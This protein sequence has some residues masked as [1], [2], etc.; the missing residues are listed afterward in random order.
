MEEEFKEEEVDGNA[1]GDD[2][3]SDFVLDEDNISI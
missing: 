1:G 2:D 3:Y